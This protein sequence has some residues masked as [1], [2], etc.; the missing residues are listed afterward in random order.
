MKNIPDN[1][2][3]SR[4]DSIGDV[5]LT[6]PVAAVLKKHF[7]EMKI[8]FIGKKYTKPVIES[9]TYVDE[10]IDA[11]D[12]LTREVTI[13]GKKPQAILHVFPTTG[14]AERAKALKIPLR[15]GTRNRLYHWY[16][17]NELVR[18]SRK[19]SDLHESQLNL[20][21][22]EFF[23]INKTYSLDEISELFGMNKL[24]TLHPSF[25]AL[26]D[27]SKYNLILHPKSQGS[28]REWGLHNFATLIKI[29]DPSKFNIFVSGTAKERALLDPLFNEAGD[30]FTDLTGKMD[31]SQFIPFIKACDGLIAN[32]TGPLH[33]CAAV[34]RE[35]IG[36]YPPMRPIHPGRW[37][38]VGKHVHVFVEHKFCDDCKKTKHVCHCMLGIRPDSVRAMLEFSYGNKQLK[39]ETV[40]A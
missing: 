23:G 6:L 15:I 29:L 40:K 13:C 12:F 1:I 31:L 18:L 37:A 3:I 33:I 22:L 35:A 17:C 16:T 27:P 5:V 8:G 24:E 19:K 25:K 32:S 21:L 38:P 10:F 14:I 4:T 28:A 39:K 20:K 34:G 2:L 26:I 7:P 36:I 30:L 11:E 9:C